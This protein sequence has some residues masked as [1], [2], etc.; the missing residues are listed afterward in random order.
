MLPPPNVVGIEAD[1]TKLRHAVVNGLRS[2]VAAE[3]AALL[4]GI[5]LALVFLG[6]HHEVEALGADAD[7]QAPEIPMYGKLPLAVEIKRHDKRVPMVGL[8]F[9]CWH[10]KATVLSFAF[11]TVANKENRLLL[12]ALS[13]NI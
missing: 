7:R 9:E 1:R 5:R 10:K 13:I 11:R 3:L 2:E 12:H 6:E 8:V 4:N